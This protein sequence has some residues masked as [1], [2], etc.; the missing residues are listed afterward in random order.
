ME[1]SGLFAGAGLTLSANQ[2]ENGELRFRMIAP[3]GSGYIRTV[4]G[5]HGGWQNAHYHEGVMETYVV[6]SGWMGF[7]QVVSLDEVSM[8]AEILVLKVGQAITTKPQV[9]HNI[10]LPAGA[11]I[12]TVKYGTEVPNPLKGADGYPAHQSFHLWSKSLTEE[13]VLERPGVIVRNMFT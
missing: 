8:L 11:V 2:M 5:Q 7:V 13:Y 4:A 6:Q 3:D 10:Y 12:H 1:V 9:A